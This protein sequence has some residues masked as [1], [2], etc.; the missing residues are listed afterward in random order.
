MTLSLFSG[1]QP[2][3]C[4]CRNA[5][6][7]LSATAEFPVSFCI[8]WATPLPPPRSSKCCQQNVDEIFGWVRCVTGN[9]R[10]DFGVYARIG[11]S[12]WISTTAD[13]G[14]N[15]LLTRELLSNF[16]EFFGGRD[17]SLATNHS[18]LL[19]IVIAIRSS[20][21]CK[22]FVKGIFATAFV[23]CCLGV[24][25]P[26]EPKKKQDALLLPIT[27]PNVNRFSKFFHLRTQQ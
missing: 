4:I 26:R 3:H 9:R 21:S 12:N 13:R 2:R 14:N 5:S 1:G 15:F 18:I 6:R 7:G 10:L 16:Y 22:E 24:L 23:V 27:L 17:V 11:I 25:L 20:G 19:V 8:A